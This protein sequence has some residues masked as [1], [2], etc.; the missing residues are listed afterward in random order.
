ML[1]SKV[2]R[3]L[4]F[5]ATVASKSLSALE[6]GVIMQNNSNSSAEMLEKIVNVVDVHIRPVLEADGGDISVISL[7]N[8]V[9]S[10][11]LQGACSRCPMASMTLKNMV[12]ETLHRLVSDNLVIN[13]V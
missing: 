12:E 8:G 4:A 10:V 3:A 9:L 2:I 1:L 5:G 13:A 7:E 11:K 6:S